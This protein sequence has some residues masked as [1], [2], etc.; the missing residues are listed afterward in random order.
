MTEPAL[1]LYSV[2][3][4]SKWGFNDGDEP[5]SW[6]DWCEEQGVDYN[7][8]GWDWHAVLRQLVREH[9]LP[10]LEQRVVLVDIDTIHNPIRAESVDDVEIDWYQDYPDDMLTPEG[11]DIPYTEVLRVAL[12]IQS[13]GVKR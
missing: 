9:L 11:V 12:E 2:S 10:K 4:L 8:V 1:R 6:L 3:L 13:K 7:I 5:D